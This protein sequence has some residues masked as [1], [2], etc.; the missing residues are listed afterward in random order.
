MKE[1]KIIKYLKYAIGEI[2]L[3]VIGILIALGVNNWNE[4][5]KDKLK[6]QNILIQLRDEYEHN[7]AHLDEKIKMR[8]DIIKAS[9]NI[10]GYI[11]NPDNIHRDSLLKNIGLSLLDPTFDPIQNDLILSGNIR[12]ISNPYLKRLLINWPSDVL[13]VQE[14]EGIWQKCIEEQFLPLTVDMGITRDI[15][16]QY[17]IKNNQKWKLDKQDRSNLFLNKSKTSPASLEILN[18]KHLE[19]NLSL[20]LSHN[21]SANI[22]SVAL[23]KR[24]NKILEI[25]EGEIN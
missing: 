2:I 1:N 12:L 6:E 7:G 17:W 8:E 22:Q 21:Y 4:E 20:A 14:L 5:R 15:I 10:L 25:L 16:H 19:G 23:R 9:K 3:V 11:N 13:T 18:N 24:I